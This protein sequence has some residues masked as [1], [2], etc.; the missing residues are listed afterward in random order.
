MSDNSEEKSE[1][2]SNR[3]LKKQRE[4]GSLPRTSDMTTILNVVVALIIMAS[5]GSHILNSYH[6]MF[7]SIFIAMLQPWGTSQVIG[8]SSLV[9]GLIAM[10]VAIVL[11]TLAVLLIV[12]TLYQGGLPFSL[13]PLIPDFNRLNPTQ[14]FSRIFG[15]RSW[16]E[17]VFHLTRALI[18]LGISAIVIWTIL[19]ALFYVDLCG[20]SCGLDIAKTLVRRWLPI[21]LFVLIVYLG[22]EM[23]VQKN[24]YLHEQ[25]MS[26]SDVKRENKEQ[27]GAPELRRERNRLRN[28]LAKEAENADKSLA[29]MCFY[30]GD[31]VVGLRYHPKDSPMP[32]VA[33]KAEGADAVH[34]RRYITEKGYPAMAHEKIALHCNKIAPGAAVN[35]D[36]FEDLAKAMAKMFDKGR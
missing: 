24:L 35:K 15:R 34:L 18:W 19:P 33:A 32:R 13:T 11:G 6:E 2:A 17:S 27:T 14:G 22:F 1:Q 7:D 31:V 20:P 26:K 29:N 30:F 25:K 21:T 8:F 36:I 23:I 9:R 10:T 16:I 28:Q 3:K 12:T 4:Q 5:T